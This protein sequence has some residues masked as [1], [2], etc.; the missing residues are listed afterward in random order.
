MPVAERGKMGAADGGLRQV[1]EAPLLARVV[2]VAPPRPVPQGEMYRFLTDQ[3]RMHQH[4][5]TARAGDEEHRTLTAAVLS[6]P[7]H[8]GG[9]IQFVERAFATPHKSVRDWILREIKDSS[10][11]LIP[12][13]GMAPDTEQMKL[14]CTLCDKVVLNTPTGISE[15]STHMIEAHTEPEVA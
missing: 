3:G 13:A 6:Y 12:Y 9:V 7:E 14:R 2:E 11:G 8:G 1:P 10:E 5:I 15:L 4:K